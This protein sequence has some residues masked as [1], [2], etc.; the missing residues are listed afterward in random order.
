MKKTFALYILFFSF[1]LAQTVFEP[2]GNRVYSFLERM[3]LKGFI[4]LNDEAQPYARR[5][6]AA[7]LSELILQKNNLNDVERNELEWFVKEFYPELRR[8]DYEPDKHIIPGFRSVYPSFAAPEDDRIRLLSYQDSLFFFNISPRAGYEVKY[9]GDAEGHSR[10]WGLRMYGTYDDYFSAFFDYMDK[11]EYGIL[12]R[13]KEFSD[14]T[15][16]FIN[17]AGPSRIEFSDMRGGFTLDWKW[18]TL[19]LQKDYVNLGHGSN[20]KLVL[21]SNAA[22]FPHIYLT[23]QPAE[24]F[25]FYYIHGFLNS[26]VIDSSASYYNRWDSEKPFLRQ[27]Y[28]GKYFAANQFTFT[29]FSGIDLSAGN[30]FVYSGRL[31]PEMF[32]PFLYYKVMDHNTARGAVDDGNGFLFLDLSVKHPK[33]FQFYTTLLVDV[34]NI[35]DILEDKNWYTTWF[36]V[37]LGAKKIDFIIPNLDVVLEYTRLNPW[38]YEHKDETTTYKHINFNL[39]HWTGQNSDNIKL[40]VM[41][42]PVS[43]LNL[44]L[45]AENFRK[46]GLKDISRAY[47]NA[48]EKQDFLYAPVRKDFRLGLNARY[49]VIH[50]LF[51][52]FD[53]RYTSVTDEDVK[54]TL[55]FQLGS[56]HNFTVSM[57]YGF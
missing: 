26:L 4:S 47:D 1:S 49:E 38:M 11:G 43:R 20:G 8:S 24:W 52:D 7:K 12:D 42:Q 45:F 14:A 28:V 57:G 23:L 48:K 33:T 15:S 3:N 34:I 37:T 25:R 18:G 13:K 31:R 44:T 54:R 35:R 6:I 19:S 46:G 16:F 22:S 36:G 53:Y 51:A 21:S 56:K 50:E 17:S 5:L 29:P 10:W 30:I 2:M 32:I 27:E 40:A 55:D 39:G 9:R 41:Y